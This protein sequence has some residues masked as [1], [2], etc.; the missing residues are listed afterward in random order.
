MQHV[1]NS[2]GGTR[3]DFLV[4]FPSVV[5]GVLL[6]ALTY[7]LGRALGLGWLAALVSIVWLG[8]NPQLTYHVREARMYPLMAV[9]AIAAAV[10][11]VRFERLPRRAA[12]WIAMIVSAVALLS[13][14]F[15]VFFIGIFAIWGLL[16]FRG[17]MRRR[18]FLAQAV[19]WSLFAGWTFFFGRAFWNPAALSEGKTW[20]FV[21][22]PW[23][24]LAG[25]VR[26]AA[27][28]YRDVPVAWLG[29]IGG[30][31]LVSLWLFGAL[32][33]PGR[34]RTF[35]VSVV[36]VPC[37]AYALVCWVKPLYHPKYVLPW[38]ALATPAVGWLLTR[39]PRLG[40]GLL[41]GSLALMITPTLHT[42]QLPYAYASPV[43]DPARQDYWL[44]PIHRQMGEY[45]R[46][47]AAATDA[48]AYGTPS[49]AD[50]YYAD[51]YIQRSLGCHN[52]VEKP[53][54]S[55]AAVAAN[56]TDLLNQHILVWYR[57]LHNANWEPSNVAQAALNQRAIALGA[58][59]TVGIPLYLY[60]SPAA[61]LSQQQPVKVRFGDVA[62]L[63]GTWLA[64]RGDLHI[65]LVWRSLA[66]HPQVSAKVFVH[67][68]NAKG[69]VIAQVDGVP[70]GW[71]RPLDTWQ[72]DEQLLDVYDLPL[73]AGQLE[74][75][76]HLEIGL[77]NPDTNVRF[78][79][80]DQAGV[81]LLNNA[82]SRQVPIAPAQVT[83]P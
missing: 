9:T 78:S 76:T 15:N 73:P 11:T 7:Q 35:L 50:C 69:E 83:S 25:L 72:R 34:A 2:V 4:R 74:A 1:W 79:A 52:L 37:V 26:S 67:L 3:N 20:S 19:A 23:D 43:Q 51:F 80:A 31:L 21:L 81:P 47:Y 66:D 12:F 65:V 38:L 40:S 44:N 24:G 18:W 42:I 13:H 62:Q 17:E 29:W 45:L 68:L 33:S 75:G 5:L 41:V 22:P 39:R 46:Q 16:T 36:V 70:V 57:D 28:G 82:F 60:A 48:F 27:F 6:L 53:G 8:L 63:T 10:M 59:N 58:E 56:L 71:T 64:Q 55:L 14:Y 32:L 54:Q 77:Y 30:T 49:I 61:I